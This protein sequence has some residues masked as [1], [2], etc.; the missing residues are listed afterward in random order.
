MQ[1]PLFR[2]LKSIN[3]E[4]EIAERAVAVLEEHITMAITQAVI[5]LERK[6]DSLQAT[7]EQGFKGNGTSIEALKWTVGIQTKVLGAAGII[8]GVVATVI[9]TAKYL[10]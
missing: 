3:I 9:T 5:P 2:A 10:S 4:D 8:G 6:I 7:I 1:V